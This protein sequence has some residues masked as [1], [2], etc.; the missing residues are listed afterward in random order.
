MKPWMIVTAGFVIGGMLWSG[1]VLAQR[2]PAACDK[3]RTPE[4]LEGQV[5]RVDTAQGKLIVRMADGT[6]HEFQADKETLQD[7][8]AGDRI[9]AKLRS[10][11]ECR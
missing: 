2:T 10:A 9:K 3:A 11:P 4:R 6:T 8:K 7:Y 5:I 1:T